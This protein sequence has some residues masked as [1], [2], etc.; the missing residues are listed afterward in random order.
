MNGDPWGGSEEAWYHTALYAAANGYKVACAAYDWPQKE[1]RFL[2]LEK[3][4]CT[5]YR[6]SNKGHLKRSVLEKITHKITKRE[7]KRY[8]HSLPFNDYDITVINLGLFEMESPYWK[9][10]YTVPKNYALL[11]H[12]YVVGQKFSTSKS[13]VLKN[14]I[15]HSK[16][17][18]FDSK[19][20]QYYL[21]EQLGIKVPNAD[22][23]HNPVTF[24]QPGQLTPYPPLQQEDYIFVMLA[25]LDTFRKAQDKLL[26]ALSGENW[27]NRNWQL[28]LYGDGKDKEML[29][30]L[31]HQNS[32]E[33]KVFLKG[34]TSQ[35]KEVL[36]KTHLLLQIT[37][38]DAMP[39]SVVEALSMSRPVIVS[40]VGD[41]PDWVNDGV[42]GWICNAV[43]I[44]GI[45]A[46]LEKAWAK[47]E[48]WN[49]MGEQSFSIFQKKFPANSS[50]YLLK[51]LGV[52]Y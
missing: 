29:S 41:M 34:Y 26:L 49:K 17:N 14:W 23:L 15:L 10:F 16:H 39:L 7:V 50:A 42:N 4:G 36:H 12:N 45:N 43:T 28:H 19:R 21:E 32:L 1:N 40:N 47:K 18:L 27:K 6:L 46:I 33:K 51:Q 5:V 37:H 3:A 24:E 22:T 25:A 20:I 52:H 35:V 13:I 9:D 31:I 30:K 8:V 11:Y 2:N 38:I 48:N 44:E